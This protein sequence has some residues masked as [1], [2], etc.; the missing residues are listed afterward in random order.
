MR[1]QA[2]QL[3]QNRLPWRWEKLPVSV[4]FGEGRLQA[5][6]SGFGREEPHMLPDTGHSAPGVGALEPAIR[7]VFK[8]T[9][10]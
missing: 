5:G 6:R 10:A 8:R 9:P 2:R 3:T 1:G 4:A 7:D